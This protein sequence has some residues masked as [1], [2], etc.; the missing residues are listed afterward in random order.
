MLHRTRNTP[1]IRKRVPYGEPELERKSR[2]TSQSNPD[3]IA[4]EPSTL[5]SHASMREIHL[6]RQVFLIDSLIPEDSR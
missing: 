3:R 2:P 5:A 1:L 6:Q 4:T